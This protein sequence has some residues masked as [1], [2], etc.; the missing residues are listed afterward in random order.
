MR[1]VKSWL[2][3]MYDY[4]VKGVYARTFGR[5]TQAS[6]DLAPAFFTAALGV[7]IT[8]AADMRALHES[9]NAYLSSEGKDDIPVDAVSRAHDILQTLPWHWDGRACPGSWTN[10]RLV[11]N[12]YVEPIPSVIYGRGPQDFQ[13]AMA[14]VERLG[15]LPPGGAF[16]P[17]ITEQ[18]QYPESSALLLSPM[19]N[20]PPT[21]DSQLADTIQQN[22]PTASVEVSAPPRPAAVPD[23]QNNSAVDGTLS[24][25][26]K[27]LIYTEQYGLAAGVALLGITL[28]VVIIKKL[29]K[30]RP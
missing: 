14:L 25:G 7:R 16:N 9:V 22:S 21:P 27:A 10:D 13:T 19:S 30:K 20:P 5:S 12:S 15:R 29:R 28:G 17:S 8:T 18:G 11:P 2:G 24:W 1:Q 3:W 26:H 23:P 6:A 4:Y